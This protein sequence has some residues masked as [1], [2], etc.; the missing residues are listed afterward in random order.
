MRSSSRKQRQRHKEAL[1][2]LKDYAYILKQFVKD[3]FTY[4]FIEADRETEK[5]TE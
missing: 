2:L 3:F 5:L 4:F 1:D